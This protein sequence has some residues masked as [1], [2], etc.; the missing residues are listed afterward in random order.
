MR[1]ERLLIALLAGAPVV[2]AINFRWIIALLILAFVTAVALSILHL[3]TR[4]LII[5]RV[6][7]RWTTAES[8]AIATVTW[9]VV[10][11]FWAPELKGA[12]SAVLGPLSIMCAA[13]VTNVALK[14][15][16]T[17]RI[18]SA[19]VNCTFAGMG[20]A[21]VGALTVRFSL[22]GCCRPAL[23]GDMVGAAPKL[24]LFIWPCLGWLVHK[25]R[26]AQALALVLMGLILVTVS[27][28]GAAGLAFATGMIVIGIGLFLPRLVLILPAALLLLGFIAAPHLGFLHILLEWPT[29]AAYLTRFSAAERVHI[30]T[31]YAELFWQRPWAGFGFRAERLLDGSMF[32]SSLPG[33]ARLH[34][35][36]EPLQVLF[37]FGVIGATLL[38]SAIAAFTHRLLRSAGPQTGYVIAPGIAFLASSLVNFSLW[39]SWWLAVFAIVLI[40]TNHLQLRLLNS[41]ARS[42]SE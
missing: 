3:N 40:F 36:N 35:H 32:P 24:I 13:L 8:L 5:E 21:I 39:E 27:R 9:M 37:E 41:Q 18:F 34:P 19:L 15:I 30:W 7:R 14:T 1:L 33:E 20:I 38:W 16:P 26:L 12:A 25:Q 17:A 2:A 4:A 23:A 29:L 31:H 42:L 11:I 28:S 22:F 10:S 6:T